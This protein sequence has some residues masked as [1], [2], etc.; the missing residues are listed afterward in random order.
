MIK[1]KEEFKNYNIV[2]TNKKEVQK[3]MDFLKNLD[4]KVEDTISTRKDYIFVYFDNRFIY[5]FI[6]STK[7]FSFIFPTQIIFI[8]LQTSPSFHFV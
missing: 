7:Y 3:T 1:N 5:S 4:F 6:A 8:I 2:C